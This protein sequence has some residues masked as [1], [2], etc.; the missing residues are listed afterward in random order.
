[1]HINKRTVGRRTSLSGTIV[2]QYNLDNNG[3]AVSSQHSQT[4][5][6]DFAFH[7]ANGVGR[8]AILLTE[9]LV[10]CIASYAGPDQ[11]CEV[12]PMGPHNSGRRALSWRL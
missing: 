11:R 8:I 1:M 4:S 7:Q 5:P 10:G 9:Q 3:K 2:A 12:L 6:E